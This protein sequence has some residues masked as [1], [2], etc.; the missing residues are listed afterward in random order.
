M[1][2]KELSPQST[3]THHTELSKKFKQV[4]TK[5]AKDFIVALH[6]EFDDSRRALLKD[7][8]LY[9]KAFDKGAIME[10]VRTTNE[11]SQEHIAGAINIPLGEIETVVD[12]LKA[13]EKPIVLCCVSGA[14]SGMAISILR[15]A[16]IDCYNGGS[17][18]HLM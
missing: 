14:R 2:I 17:Y 3:R 7:R 8:V 6:I 12:Q 13:K 5:V 4:L 9:Q 15:D 1:G 16:G 18:T 11:F 10:D